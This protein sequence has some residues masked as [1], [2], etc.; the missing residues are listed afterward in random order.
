MKLHLKI[1]PNSK[2]DEWIREAD[3]SLKLKIRAQ[4]IEGKANK[5]LIDYLSKV[6]HLP[7]SSIVL[8]K[9][10][11]NAFKTFEIDAEEE[12]VMEKIR[13]LLGEGA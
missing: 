10:E 12:V 6:L 5:Y 3:G 13:S 9:G 4:P 8:A 11:T 2:T 1:K 7:K